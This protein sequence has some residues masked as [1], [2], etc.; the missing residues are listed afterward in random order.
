MSLNLFGKYSNVDTL[1][2]LYN[3]LLYDSS[4][5]LTLEQR[6]MYQKQYN[7]I[8]Y[9]ERL[10]QQD[11]QK[12]EQELQKRE[13][14]VKDRENKVARNYLDTKAKEEA[15]KAVKKGLEDFINKNLK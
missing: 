13:Q 1:E 14:K 7:Q 2:E 12:K 6:Y 9:M 15:D 8:K 5:Y 4:K 11:F 10:R 3:N